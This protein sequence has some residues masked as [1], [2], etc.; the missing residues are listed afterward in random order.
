MG[1]GYQEVQ[2]VIS[3]HAPTRGA[4]A[5]AI[6][7]TQYLMKFQSTLPREERHTRYQN[8]EPVMGISIHAPTRGA[9]AVFFVHCPMPLFQSTLPREERPYFHFHCSI[10]LIFQST[11]PREERQKTTYR[12]SE[13]L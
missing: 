11:L 9:T 12:K 3:I 13:P 7:L 6:E 8:G 5:S 4:T 2:E 10:S 1:D